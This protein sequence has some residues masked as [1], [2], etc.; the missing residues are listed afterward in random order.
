MNKRFIL[1]VVGLLVVGIAAV[2]LIQKHAEWQN[3][4]L[5]GFATALTEKQIREALK[6]Q[7]VSEQPTQAT[8]SSLDLSRTVRLAIG[9]LADC[10]A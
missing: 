9:G 2:W 5:H 8:L 3:N 4:E 10:R 1:S 6:K 7:G